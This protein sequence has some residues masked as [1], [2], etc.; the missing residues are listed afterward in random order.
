MNF[1]RLT[2]FALGL[3][4]AMTTLGESIEYNKEMAIANRYAI[5]AAAISDPRTPSSA[6][7][8]NV[9]TRMLPAGTSGKVVGQFI[10]NYFHSFAIQK[11]A[12]GVAVVPRPLM[13]TVLVVPWANASKARSGGPCAGVS[14][15]LDPLLAPFRLIAVMYRPDL[16]SCSSGTLT[17]AGEA[18]F[19]YGINVKIPTSLQ[20]LTQP[21]TAIIPFV[22]GQGS[23]QSL[24]ANLF[25]AFTLIVENGLPLGTG[26]SGESRSAA[27]WAS[28][29]HELGSLSCTASGCGAYVNKLAAIIKD[30]TSQKLDSSKPNGFP[31]NHL[32][33]NEVL[34]SPTTFPAPA[35]WEIRS[36]VLSGTGA[37]ASL[38]LDFLDDKTPRDGVDTANGVNLSAALLNWVKSNIGPIRDQAYSIPT[39]LRAVTS[40]PSK[41]PLPG[42]PDA[43]F[44]WLV[45]NAGTN[46]ESRQVAEADR[47]LFAMNTCNGC[48][49][50]EMPGRF[51]ANQPKTISNLGGF[52]H[53]NPTAAPAEGNDEQIFSNF[54]Q[55]QDKPS[56]VK[57]MENSL[58]GLVDSSCGSSIPHFLPPSD[59]AF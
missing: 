29:F 4:L 23:P 27:S 45:S 15:C 58:S 52:Y 59:F 12:S 56:R 21:P 1:G 26:P 19:V 6:A 24:A 5:K 35:I 50:D 8:G 14:A 32:R 51:N 42:L 53:V 3:T 36:F 38:K 37:T 49:S 7:L 22:G 11:S 28:R 48:H 46:N 44:Q 9:L 33:T 30:T 39:S 13:E 41:A 55:V 31:L 25:D 40:H 54:I 10:Y 16:S 2:L 20:E 57:A 17:Q 43:R 34:A 47:F 18:R